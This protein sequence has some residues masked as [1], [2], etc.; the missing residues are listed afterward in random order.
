MSTYPASRT[1][2]SMP[3]NT[4][5]KKGFDTSKTITAMASLRPPRSRCA[6]ELRTNPVAST[7]SSTRL[8]VSCPT[9]G[10]LL[11]AFETVAGDTPARA[12]TSRMVTRVGR[13]LDPSTDS[14]GA[15]DDFARDGVGREV[16]PRPSPLGSVASRG[17]GR[18]LALICWPLTRERDRGRLSSWPEHVLRKFR[19][20]AASELRTRQTGTSSARI[21]AGDR[22][23]LYRVLPNRAKLGAVLS[24]FD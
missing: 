5:A 1:T 10:R 11:S 20:D 12:A 13:G 15:R 23:V 19:P 9:P 24:S 2:A 16:G 3:C 17:A 8:R 7:A 6:A 14:K 22:R 18:C 21:D 4:S